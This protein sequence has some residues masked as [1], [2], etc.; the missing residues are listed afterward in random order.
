MRK[1]MALEM[2]KFKMKTYVLASVISCFVL[3]A[4]TYFISVVS[5]VEKD[6]VFQSYHNI[7]KFVGI[8]SM[9]IFIILSSV[10]H[11]RIT[12]EDYIGKKLILLF[13]YPKGRKNVFIAKICLVTLFTVIALIGSSGA[14]L[15]IFSITESIFPIVPDTLTLSFFLSTLQTILLT[16]L[17]VGALSILAMAAGFIKKSTPTTIVTSFALAATIG[18]LTMNSNSSIGLVLLGILIVLD[19]LVMKVLTK[20]V[21]EM[22]AI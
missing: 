19:V 6:P 5:V 3:I 9:I 18:N 21:N 13:S 1:L 11:S 14:C 17:I 4:F 2:K 22:D 7:F 15:V 12:I 16:A 10:M 8:M 20:K